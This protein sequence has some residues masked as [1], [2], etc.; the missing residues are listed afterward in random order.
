MADCCWLHPPP[1]PAAADVA[2]L[3]AESLALRKTAARCLSRCSAVPG[4]DVPEWVALVMEPMPDVSPSLSQLVGL[5]WHLEAMKG[6]GC[7][8]IFDCWGMADVPAK[9]RDWLSSP[10]V[11]LGVVAVA[12]GVGCPMQKLGAGIACCCWG[13]PK[14]PNVA[15]KGGGCC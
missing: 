14:P 1:V 4:A 2:P 8:A 3:P 7:V 15:A 9:C 5:F 12:M 6:G 13:W 11:G 10:T